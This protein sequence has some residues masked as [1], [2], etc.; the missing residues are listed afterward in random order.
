M[1][2]TKVDRCCDGGRDKFDYASLKL[3]NSILLRCG[4][5]DTHGNGS[6][7]M[8]RYGGGRIAWHASKMDRYYG[9]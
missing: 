8:M 6:L 2:P 7:V 9:A 4:K 5:I 3:R 1:E